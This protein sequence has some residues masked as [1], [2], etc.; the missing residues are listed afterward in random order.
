MKSEAQLTGDSQPFPDGPPAPAALPD[1][2]PALPLPVIEK[3]WQR[4]FDAGPA[5]IGQQVAYALAFSQGRPE[6]TALDLFPAAQPP[7]PTVTG[8]LARAAAADALSVTERLAL[9]DDL[10]RLPDPALRARGLL[11]L[12][13]S[14]A[15]EKRRETLRH[16]YE[17]VITVQAQSSAP[18]E[19]ARLLVELLDQ[20]HQAASDELPGGLM[21]EI[22]DIAS[23]MQGLEARLRSLTALAPY[24]S[25]TVRIAL[26]L[27]VLDSIAGTNQPE[28]Q[29][30]AL[31]ALAPFLPDEVQHRALTVAT[32]IQTP[33]ARARALTAL[34]QHLPPRLQPRLRSAALDA[35]GSIEHEPERAAALAAFAPHLEQADA[36]GEDFP[37]LLERALGLAVDLQRRD[38]RA[39]ALVGL[40][41]RLPR[42]LQGEALAV[43]NS[44][45][46]EH[47]RAL[48][49]A[50]LAESLP[51]D[52]AA[53]GALAVAHNIRQRDARFLALKA[54]GRRLDGGAA[55][56]IWLDA[57]AVALALPRQLEQVM[58]LAELAPNLPD[59]LRHRALSSA[60]ETARGITRERAR[61]R[62][63]STLALLLAEEPELL[64][65]ALA[66]AHTLT[67]PLE[68]ISALIAMLPSLPDAP[69]LDITLEEILHAL[70]DVDLEYRQTRALVSLAPHLY[71]EYLENALE[72]ALRIHDP[73][74][75]ATTLAALLPRIEAPQRR[76]HLLE[77]ALQA[78]H[79]VT[80]HYDRVTALTTL[81][82]LTSP[83]QQQALTQ[84][85]LNAVREIEDDYDRASGVALLAPLLAEE[86][87]PPVLPPETQVLREALLAICRLE[88]IQARARLFADI[89]PTWQA[90]HPARISYALW[91]E[92]LV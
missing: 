87:A 18:Y 68:R 60:L 64:A 53:V 34:A 11:L 77:L 57:L 56:R 25:S 20:V 45:T 8:P 90:M 62:A 15:L 32:Y 81:R 74:D 36:T 29:A 27:A 83:S 63:L 89:V 33:A 4:A 7:T 9:L 78:A 65:A 38:A 30:G 17:A 91:C 16:C 88:S 61:L 22:L 12:A 55:E 31:V 67:N 72:I 50:E 92:V 3:G 10:K 66:D 23:R 13:P 5:Q 41:A 21:A 69:T 76:A 54:L 42:H 46:D 28:A 40:Q 84:P 52:I 2:W 80:D 37:A 49:L 14:L 75:R 43:V 1:G 24:L 6:R 79:T 26:I 82:P 48:L 86:D 70:L 59:E 51:P 35:I 58:A 85:I 47:E 39:R 73:Y 71:G 44:I 19:A